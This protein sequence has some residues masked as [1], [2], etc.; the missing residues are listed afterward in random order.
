MSLLTGIFNS[1]GGGGGALATFSKIAG[2][3]VGVV[4]LVPLFIKMFMLT[5]DEGD[6]AIRT[7]FG[8]AIICKKPR[9]AKNYRLGKRKGTLKR[10]AVDV[11]D[12]IV[13]H[14][15]T[16][17]AFPL[18]Y[19]YRKVDVKL[20]PADLPGKLMRDAKGRLHMV[21]AS[22]EW[23]RGRTGHNLR[24]SELG[25]TNLLEAV[26]NRVGASLHDVVR[27]L[28]EEVLPPNR[29]ISRMVLDDCAAIILTR[30]G[31]I[32]HSVMLTGDG[33]TDGYMISEAL[34]ERGETEASEEPASSLPS[35]VAAAVVAIRSH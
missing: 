15:G 7:R 5:V 1:T 33:L 6:E 22:I 21:D 27:S 12:Y 34:R 8:K 17:W 11:G 30:Y 14:P 2:T 31:V 4:T 32:V 26:T 3:I 18:F 20:T 19:W 9:P 10:E 13:S 25:V 28:K 16:H 35:S 24:Q 23:S 29:V